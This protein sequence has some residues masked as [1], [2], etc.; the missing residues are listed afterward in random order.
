MYAHTHTR[1]YFLT[2]ARNAYDLP[3]AFF[4]ATRS[5]ETHIYSMRDIVNTIAQDLFIARLLDPPSP[6][7]ESIFL[8]FPRTD[9]EA[10]LP[11]EL[12]VLSD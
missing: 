10:F 9:L 12:I 1:R 5:H 11:C 8:D 2:R 3:R 4:G 6:P 7:Y